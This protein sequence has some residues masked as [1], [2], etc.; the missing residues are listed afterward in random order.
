MAMKIMQLP[1]KWMT[2][3]SLVILMAMLGLIG[4]PIFSKAQGTGTTM[5]LSVT[6]DGT[7]ANGTSSISSISGDGRYIA[8]DS[9][10]TNLVSGDTNLG[11]DIFVHDRITGETRRISVASN[12]AQG[13]G[14]GGS[15]LPDISGNGRYVAF[16]S[17]ASN[18]VSGDTNGGADVFV[19]DLHTGQTS[20]ASITSEGSQGLYVSV[21]DAPAISNDGRFVAFSSN[22]PYVSDDNNGITDVFV[23]DRLLEETSRISISTAGTEANGHSSEPDISVDGRYV[24]FYSDASNLVSGDVGG[25]IDVFLHDRQT[26]ETS[27]VSVNS[28]GVQGNSHSYDQSISANGRYVVFRSEATNLVSNDTNN[29]FDIFVHDHQT[30]QI[31]RASLNTNGIQANGY[32]QNPVISSDGRFVA[33]Y[34]GA[35]NLIA[36]DTNS[37]PD[38]FIRD[39]QMGVTNRVSISANGIEGNGPSDFAALSSDGRFVTFSS[40]SSNLV[41]NDTNM[42]PDVFGL[43]WRIESTYLPMMTRNY[44]FQISCGNQD[45]EPNNRFSEAIA[46]LPLCPDVQISGR[47][48]QAN[49]SIDLYRI[50][51]EADHTIRV[52]LNDLPSNSNYDLYLY[53]ST[54]NV[55][56]FEDNQGSQDEHLIFNAERGD[57]FIQV[58][59]RMDDPSSDAYQLKWGLQ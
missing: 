33:F 32:S 14:G 36:N 34:S 35:T 12:G 4:F 15:T 45:S 42:L 11:S 40:Y 48:S 27:R 29:D 50:E 5:R 22:T 59:P 17:E 26:G 1:P 20:L 39:R 51:L 53:D 24:S 13:V 7:Q 58:A 16:I 55:K 30:G 21:G 57:Y 8:F 6:S 47:A 41:D 31:T 28:T 56:A 3:L 44:A 18:L 23:R 43:Q 25:K 9:Q 10:A 2:L 54:F 19:H 37:Y 46:N 38:I 49:D 52:D